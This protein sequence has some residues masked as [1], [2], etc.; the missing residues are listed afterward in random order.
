MSLRRAFVALTDQHHIPYQL[1][2]NGVLTPPRPQ[3]VGTGRPIG[4]GA[5][6]ADKITLVQGYLGAGNSGRACGT[7]NAFANEVNAQSARIGRALAA[8]L[9]AEA[10][11][12]EA[13]IRC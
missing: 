1:T 10:R 4:P 7:L 2:Q 3:P 13:V 11:Q 12:I 9:V 5:S 8:Q 6:L